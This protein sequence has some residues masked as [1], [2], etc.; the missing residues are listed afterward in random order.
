MT[1]ARRSSTQ[2]IPVTVLASS[3]AT[4]LLSGCALIQPPPVPR[5]PR[6]GLRG[7]TGDA[8]CTADIARAHA[9]FAAAGAAADDPVAIASAHATAAEAM[10]AY[11]VCLAQSNQR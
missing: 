3:L 6:F 4:L 11:H 8:T 9:A 7:G 5:M 1:M 2:S 10:S